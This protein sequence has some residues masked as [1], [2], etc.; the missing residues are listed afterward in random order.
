MSA[1]APDTA[2]DVARLE[3]KRERILEQR[4][5]GLLSREKCNQQFAAIDRE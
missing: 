3:G 1:A 4:A 2:K 5:D